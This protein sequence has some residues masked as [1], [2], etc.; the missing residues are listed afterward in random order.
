MRTIAEAGDGH[1]VG[2][3]LP[4]NNSKDPSFM[5]SLTRA[6]QSVHLYFLV[7]VS[8][9]NV[10]LTMPVLSKIVCGG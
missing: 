2:G 6:S 10:C 9:H 3:R 4:R 1:G 5:M 8:F 7:L